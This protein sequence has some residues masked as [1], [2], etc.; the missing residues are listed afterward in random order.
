MKDLYIVDEVFENEN[1]SDLAN[2]NDTIILKNCYLKNV[3]LITRNPKVRLED[4]Y[5]VDSIV[6]APGYS[7]RFGNFSA[8]NGC[9]GT[10]SI[11]DTPKV[12]CGYNTSIYANRPFSR[13]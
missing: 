6:K 8:F 4:C 3:S 7:G 5:M 1:L 2:S 11:M 12:T 9:I 10:F 13:A